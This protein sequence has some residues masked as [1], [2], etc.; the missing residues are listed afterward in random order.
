MPGGV[1]QRRSHC[2]VPARIAKLFHLAQQP[3]ARQRKV[4]TGAA[5]IRR[6]RCHHRQLRPRA[7][8]AGCSRRYICAPSA[9]QRAGNRRERQPLPMQTQYHHEP[10]I[11]SAPRPLPPIGSGHQVIG[12]RCAAR[13]SRTGERAGRSGVTPGRIQTTHLGRITPSV[14]AGKGI[15]MTVVPWRWV[16]W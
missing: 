8:Q 15:K 16:Q 2:S 12:D 7:K 11:E 1:S 9:F 10:T 5:D 4:A 14:T 3:A 13:V 6:E